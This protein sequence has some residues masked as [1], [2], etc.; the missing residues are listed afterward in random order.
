MRENYF[1]D[2]TWSDLGLQLGITYPKLKEIKA[3]NPQNVSGCL[4]ECLA[5]W[6]ERNYDIENYDKPTME[7]LAAALRRM[8]S[9]A[10]ASGIIG[11][12]SYKKFKTS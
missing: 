7:S 12:P 9:R 2:N 4:Q 5:I 10:V 3:N 8:G 1:S 6:L 11:E